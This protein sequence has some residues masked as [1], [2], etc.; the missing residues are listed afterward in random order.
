MKVP[1]PSK[2]PSGNWFIRLRLG[3]KSIPITAATQKECIK[4]ATLI[5]AE[6]LAGKRI[7]KSTLTVS[8]AID[9]YILSRSNTV[10]PSTIRGY[11]MIQKHRFQSQM[12]KPISSE[13]NWQKAVNAEAARLSAK[14][15]QNSWR[16]LCSVMREN[17]ITP[18]RVTLPQV[19]K[20]ARPFL[21]PEQIPVFVA[22]LKNH[23]VEIPALLALHSLRRSEILALT[24]DK[25][26]LSAGTIRISGACVID[27]NQVLVTKATNKNSASNRTI[28]IMIPE[29]RAA[30]A[31]C[32][33]KEGRLVTHDPRNIYR[34][35]NKICKLLGFPEVGV[36][37]LRHSFASLAYHVGLSEQETMALGGWA[38]T[39]TMH[40]IYTHLAAAD[41]L[42][43]QNKIAAFFANTS[44]A[45]KNVNEN[46]NE[47]SNPLRLQAV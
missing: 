41:R 47:I 32:P 6:H 43:A 17:D 22:A 38:D 5:K 23:S 37:G 28:P 13:I 14:T 27:E 44:P 35:I 21:E 29:L 45:A 25:I 24:W 31:A 19:V 2:L 16:F 11:R 46:V 33:T 42:K 4:Q 1:E 8:Q 36:H 9:A 10:S 34:R 12:G 7:E 30:L 3:G 40:N 18:P 20:N 26:N 39:K 15:V